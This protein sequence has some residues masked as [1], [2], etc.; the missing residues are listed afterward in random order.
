[1]AEGRQAGAV[2]PP[3]ARGNNSDDGL[4]PIAEEAANILRACYTGQ[5]M[6][7][8]R[9]LASERTL[10]GEKEGDAEPKPEKGVHQGRETAKQKGGAGRPGG[11]SEGDM[12]EEK[13]AAPK[14]FMS[15]KED[16]L[17][18]HQ[19][20]QLKDTLLRDSKAEKG[21]RRNRRHSRM[22]R[23]VEK[24]HPSKIEHIMDQIL[25]LDFHLKQ[26]HA[27]TVQYKFSEEEISEEMAVLKQNDSK[28]RV[29]VYALEE[30]M[31]LKA[32]GDATWR[33]HGASVS[34]MYARIREEMDI[35]R[36]KLLQQTLRR[37]AEI[38]RSMHRRGEDASLKDV[39]SKGSKVQVLETRQ[40]VVRV[41]TSIDH[42]R[43][44]RREDSN[45][46]YGDNGDEKHARGQKT[47]TTSIIGWMER[48]T[49][50]GERLLKPVNAERHQEIEELKER[51]I[52]ERRQIGFGYTG[53]K[54]VAGGGEGARSVFSLIYAEKRRWIQQND[55]VFE[56]DGE[57]D[58]DDDW[59]G[60][61][62]ERNLL[63][64]P[65]EDHEILFGPIE[66]ILS[67]HEELL[68]G[69]TTT[70]LKMRHEPMLKLKWE[71]FLELNKRYAEGGKLKDVVI[72]QTKSNNP[73]FRKFLEEKRKTGGSGESLSS[74]LIIQITRPL[75][76]E[77]LLK[78]LIKH[79]PKDK[80]HLREELIETQNRIRAFSKEV[81]AHVDVERADKVGKCRGYQ[82]L[83][84]QYNGRSRLLEPLGPNFRLYDGKR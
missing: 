5:G 50:G 14:S 77:L 68:E 71:E 23:D 79:A 27:F 15:P 45:G 32:S 46:E 20:K 13:N 65:N 74:L 60:R 33:S 63:R 40:S 36:V 75:K 12:K 11:A 54:G 57:A 42:K 58:A 37:D 80:I 83:L 28:Q 2:P 72:E 9:D 61:T 55:D 53:K 49:P 1:M 38:W 52:K 16:A 56:D 8:P 59:G 43:R 18:P 30:H 84:D 34:R 25:E 47:S 78:E 39:L 82:L 21:P 10:S 26:L 24:H 4:P 29:T 81:N 51:F 17:P 3:R 76:Y 6:P 44:H 69:L 70:S 41:K 64:Y 67:F 22:A 62:T 73:K 31:R 7:A 48:F 35:C 19:A 66:K